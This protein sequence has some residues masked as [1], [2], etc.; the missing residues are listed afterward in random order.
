MRLLAVGVALSL[1]GAACGDDD[2]GETG[3]EGTDGGS[4]AEI[5]AAPGFDGTTIRI[6]A[7]ENTG[8]PLAAIGGPLSAGNAAYFEYINSQGGIAGK[9]PIEFVREETGYNPTTAGERLAATV[10]N[11]AMYVQILGTPVVDALLG[12]LEEANVIAS[13]ASLDSDWVREPN[14]LPVQAPYQIQAI[15]A[16]DWY[17]SQAENEGDVL[18][19]LASDDEYGDAGTQGVDFIAEALDIEVAQ[20]SSFPSPSGRQGAA[21]DF[22]GQV[23]EL[24]DADCGVVFAVATLADTASIATAFAGRPQFT[25][26][27]I[28]QSPTWNTAFAANPWIQEHFLLAGEGPGYGDTS[29]PGM[30]NVIQIREEYAPDVPPDIYFNFGV[31]QA[32]AAVA[33]LEK[34]VELG[35]LSRDG[36]ANALEALG[37]VSFDGLAGDWTYGAPDDRVPPIKSTIFKPN[38]D[39]AAFPTGLEVVEQDYEADSAGDYEFGSE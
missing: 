9:Y 3:T 7:L 37:T 26:T 35:D 33:L 22:A 23:R 12:D 16:I 39:K 1:F 18:C 34:A 5:E 2:D 32:I 24:E 14:L 8:P 27:V 13:P 29:V 28:G 36:L 11:V 6:G 25:P 19:V 21:H 4:A 31:V 30:A 17:Y 15:N 10:D 20:K 38:G